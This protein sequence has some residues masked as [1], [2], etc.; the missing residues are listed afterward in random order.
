MNHHAADQTRPVVT[1]GA[2]LVRLTATIVAI[3]LA[4]APVRATTLVIIRT[5]DQVIIAADSR[6]VWRGG[7]QPPAADLQARHTR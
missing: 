3:L 1:H 2:S 7:D 6:R 5:P 4:D